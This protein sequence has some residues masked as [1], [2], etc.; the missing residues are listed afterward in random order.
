MSV[1]HAESPGFKP[2]C[3]HRCFLALAL[4][5]FV[6]N[7]NKVASTSFLTLFSSYFSS[8]GRKM[9]KSLFMKAHSHSH[10]KSFSLYFPFI[11][12]LDSLSLSISSLFIVFVFLS[13]SLYRNLYFS[14]FTLSLYVFDLFL[15]RRVDRR[16]K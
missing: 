8:E 7:L 11:S 6:Q 3:L 15:V 12:G 13:L 2:R 9:N 10:S 1:S 4:K 16:E 14:L 5:I